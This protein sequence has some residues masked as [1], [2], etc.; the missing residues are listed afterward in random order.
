M[1][2]FLVRFGQRLFLSV[3]V[4]ILLYSPKGFCLNDR[5]SKGLTYLFLLWNYLAHFY[6]SVD[7]KIVKI[8]ILIYLNN[9]IAAMKN[10]TSETV[11]KKSTFSGQHTV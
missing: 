2:K 6:K 5:C 8:K 9:H 11:L 3:L 4:T 10:G 7:V 1:R